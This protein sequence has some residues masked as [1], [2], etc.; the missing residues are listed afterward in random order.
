M[1]KRN[2]KLQSATRFITAKIRRSW[3]SAL[4]ALF[5][6]LFSYIFSNLDLAFEDDSVVLKWIK[7]AQHELLSY[8]DARET[9]DSIV[10]IN[11]CYDTSL[12]P[13]HNSYG[14]PAGTIGITDR[15]KLLTLLQ[16][17]KTHDNYRYIL[18][19]ISLSTIHPTEYDDSLYST[20]ASMRDIVV[21]QPDSLPIDPRIASKCFDTSYG[22]TILNSDCVKYPLISDNHPTMP[23]KVFMD[24]TGRKISHW[25]PFYTE[26]GH[27]ARRTIYP[28]YTFVFRTQNS[29]DVTVGAD[30]SMFYNIGSDI[31]DLYG[32]D[33]S[34]TLF[35]NSI[36][37]IGDFEDS[38]F[39]E[40][41]A[42]RIAGPLIQLNVLTSLMDD[43]HQIPYYLII[44]LYLIF[45]LISDNLLHKQTAPSYEDTDDY[46]KLSNSISKGVVP[47]TLLSTYYSLL[48]IIL[49]ALIYIITG[50]AYDILFTGILIGVVHWA[51]KLIRNFRKK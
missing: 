22:I 6:L 43:A 44:I 35:D 26:G 15:Q 19:D 3:G 36:I 38:D 5:F 23:Y 40:T 18:M 4:L 50:Q 13:V 31:I 14:E 10:L 24:M 8:G 41:Y 27:L 42:G 12:V 21:A 2:N 39:H 29:N 30:E 37:V 46:L 34:K 1:Q 49:C 47:L 16:W 48:L 9:P 17:L 28:N 33:D 45:F 32:F 11:T 7:V 25:G 51:F 20:L